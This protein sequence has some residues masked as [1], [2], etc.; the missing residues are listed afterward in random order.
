MAVDLDRSERRVV[1]ESFDAAIGREAHNVQPRPD[2]FWQQLYN[3][4]QW[5]DEPFIQLLEPELIGAERL[6]PRA[7]RSGS[8]PAPSHPTGGRSSSLSLLCCSCHVLSAPSVSSSNSTCRRPVAVFGLLSRIS[9]LTITRDRC[10]VIVPASRST[11]RHASPQTS[12][13][14]MPVQAA[15]RHMEKSRSSAHKA[16]KVSSSSRVQTFI[17]P[18]PCASRSTFGGRT[19][20]AGL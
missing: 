1:L 9:V 5:E 16:R 18:A 3:L 12:P 17:S 8:W 13:R 20:S 6:A 19:A 4:L 11:S 10:T 15:K 14:R 7:A 2:L